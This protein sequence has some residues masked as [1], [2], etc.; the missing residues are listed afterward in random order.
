MCKYRKVLL[1]VNRAVYIMSAAMLVAGLVLTVAAKPVIADPPVR[2]GDGMVEDPSNPG[3]C[4]CDTAGHFTEDPA[5]PGTCICE[6][7]YESAQGGKSCVLASPPDDQVCPEGGGWDKVPTPGDNTTYTYTIPDGKQVVEVC[8]KAGDNTHTYN[9]SPTTGSIGITQNQFMNPAGTAY[10]GLSH[11]SFRLQD[12]DTPPTTVNVCHVP[13]YTTEVMTEAEWATHHASNPFDFLYDATNPCTPP[14]A[15]VNVCHVPDYTTEVMTEEAWATHQVSNPDDFL[16]SLSEPCEPVIAYC[17]Y[18]AGENLWTQEQGYSSAISDPDYSLDEGE[19]CPEKVSYCHYSNDGPFGE[20][21]TQLSNYPDFIIQPDFALEVGEICTQP[22][23][24]L[25]PYCYSV[26][27]DLMQWVIDNP[28]SAAIT[29]DS[30]KI[31]GILQPGVLV[32]PTGTSLF[33]TTDLGTHTVDLYWGLTGH[34]SLE[35]TIDSCALPI[36]YVNVCHVPG[37][38]T[39]VM[40]EGDW[41][42]W[43]KTHTSDFLIT[44]AQP[45]EIPPL[46]I[47]ETGGAGGPFIP[48]TGADLTQPLNGWFFGG[49]GMFGFGMILTGL[50]KMFNL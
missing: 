33:T 15:T 20:T 4:I 40:S 11:A 18:D 2:C 22:T 16:Y 19:T 8:Y 39:D 46:P 44:S 28:N 43:Q 12:Q 6:S 42:N 25:D 30:W 32:A 5:T 36:K 7:G 3:T 24:I 37:Y 48:V 26:P 31:D 10:L 14:P 45:C 9:V 29:I 38:T 13:G 41:E 23:L 27:G 50:R 34:T 1:F 47:P 17:H 49:F 35:W 21:W